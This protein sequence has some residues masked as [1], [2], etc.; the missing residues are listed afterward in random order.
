MSPIEAALAAIKA[1]EPGEKL[2]YTQ[3]AAKYGVDRRTLARRHQGATTSRDTQAQ[4]LQALHPQQEQELLRYIERLTRQGLPP[5][6]PMIR[7][8]ASDI[9][10]KELGRGWVDRFTQRYQVDLISHWATGIDRSRH[11]AD[12]EIKYSLYFELLNSKLSQYYIEPRNTYNMDEKGFM[13]GV[14]TRSKRVFSR[15]LYEEGKLKAH[16]QDGNREWITLLACICADGSHIEPSLIYQSASGSIQDSWLQAFNP[17]DHRVHF[18]SSPSGWTNNELGLAWLK[19][20]FDR[21]TKPKAGRSYRLLILDGHGSHLTMDFIEYCDHNRILL[22]V[23]PP[24]S[25]HTLQP[26]DVVMFKPLSSAY[27]AQLASF[28][29]RCQGLTSMSKRDFYPMF[30]AAW[31]ASFKEATILKAFKATGISPLNPEVILKRFNQPA[32]TGQSSD[33]DSSALSASDWRKIRQLVDRAVADR[34]QR[35]ISKLNQTIHQLS[36]RSVLAEHENKRLKEALI[37][38]KK[39]RKRGKALPLQAGEEYHGGAVFWSPGKVKDARDRLHQQE[40]EEEQ[41]RLQKAEKARD[42]EDQRQ[43]KA[44]NIKVRRKARAEARIARQAVKA[45]EAVERA[46]RAAARKAQQRLQRAQKTSQK[47]KKR[48]LKAPIKAVSKN[49]AVVQPQGGGEAS[50]AAPSP[51][52]SQSRHGRSIRLPSKYR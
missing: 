40:L 20:V 41:Q 26:L 35:K 31:E 50:G 28:M 34:D 32:Q 24:H 17:D 48:S 11:Q 42:R 3:I 22:A 23:Y 33:S 29:E 43:A 25:T 37:N 2:I 19:Q 21:S 16:I 46:S 30:I 8:F 51:P 12:S 4:N 6:R 52:P 1:L 44:Q 13:L 47:G 38:E 9:A 14:L 45:R 49:R 7:R 15:R 18:A 27:S 5:T 39:R 10:K 36:I